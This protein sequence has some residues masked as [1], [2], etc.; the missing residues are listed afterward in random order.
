VGLENGRLRR[1]QQAWRSHRCEECGWDPNTPIV[2]EVIWEDYGGEPSEDEAAE[3]ESSCHGC[4]QP[5]VGHTV[6]WEDL[7]PPEREEHEHDY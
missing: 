2:Y 3:T 7:P 5:L 6:V 1:L 4:G